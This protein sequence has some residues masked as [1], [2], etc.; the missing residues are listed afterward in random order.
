MGLGSNWLL[1]LL[2][3]IFLGA[4]SSRAGLTLV[5]RETFQGVGTLDAMN[6]GHLGTISHGS[7]YK[8]AVGPRIPGDVTANG[9]GWSADLQVSGVDITRNHKVAIAGTAAASGWV[10]SAWHYLASVAN[11]ENNTCVLEASYQSNGNPNVYVVLDSSTGHF[12]TL[13]GIDYRFIDTGIA[14]PVGQFFELR[15]TCSVVSGNQC[16]YTL[17]F[18]LAGATVWTTLLSGTYNFY[19]AM[20]NFQGGEINPGG[21]G[22]GTY[23]GRYGMPSLYISDNYSMDSTA[24]IADVVDPVPG[25]YAWF[26]DPSTGND[27]NDGT[28]AGT[29]WASVNKINAESQFCGMFARPGY[30]SGDTLT[31]NT[32]A[33]N[34]P[35]G[36]A[37]LNLATRGLNVLQLGGGVSG[38]G[39]IQAWGRCPVLAAGPRSTAR[40]M[41]IRRP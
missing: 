35:L 18:R 11:N 26:C 27:T 9:L 25:P 28:T 38:A 21:G 7:F 22:Q 13:V 5:T 34:L 4:A 17:N 14:Y 6:P 2:V 12:V 39:E 33:A 23:T 1:I 15:H 29:A 10:W 32:L 3:V 37:S 31:I 30:A 20:D 41:Y 8:R 16:R 19:G 40:P 24:A 36:T